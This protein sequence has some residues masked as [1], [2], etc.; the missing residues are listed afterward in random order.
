MKHHQGGLPRS[1]VLTP[2][3]GTQVVMVGLVPTIHLSASSG[4]CWTLDPRDEPEDDIGIFCWCQ[5]SSARYCGAPLTF[6]FLHARHHTMC[7]R[8]SRLTVPDP[9][10]A[11]PVL[12]AVEDADHENLAAADVVEN[13]V[14]IFQFDEEA[15]GTL[16][17]LHAEMR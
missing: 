5:N 14:E 10:G 12:G 7:S 16:I 1:S 2:T 11:S 8:P 4:A 15:H 17:R 6:I 9:D 13:A 3:V